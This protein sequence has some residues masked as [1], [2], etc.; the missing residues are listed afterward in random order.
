MSRTQ[1]KKYMMKCRNTTLT[2]TIASS[3]AGSELQ[4]VVS[5][6]TPMDVQYM[7]DAQAHPQ[8]GAI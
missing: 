8:L 5:T 2:N 7:L 1:E 4:G 3:V 6:L